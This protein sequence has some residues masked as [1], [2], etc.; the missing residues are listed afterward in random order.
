MF[1]GSESYVLQ[2]SKFGSVQDRLRD[3]RDDVREKINHFSCMQ[4]AML[5]IDGFRLDKAVQM[6]ADGLA[7]FSRAQR[8][9][10]RNLGKDNFL[11]L[12]ELL[13]R[14]PLINMYIGRGK[15]PHQHW[16]TPAE[17]M[18]AS[19]ESD[20]TEFI[21]DSELASLDGSSFS[22]EVYYGLVELLG[23]DGKYK[24]TSIDFVQL[25][26]D[27]LL[28]ADM[29]NPNTGL[30]DPR[31]GYGTT[32]QDLF[33][34]PTLANGT[35]RQLLGNFI[36]TLLMPGLPALTWGE[37]Q[38]AYILDNSAGDYVYGRAPM[39]SS[40]AWQIHGCY[41]LD[42]DVY[43]DLPL[44]RAR[45]GCHDDRVSLDQ[46][47]PAHP[48][49]NALKRMYE[50]REQYPALNDG[51][52]LQR[53]SNQT[54]DVYLPA[55]QLSTSRGIFSVYRSVVEELQNFEG[56]MMG[57]QG[58]WLVFSNEHSSTEFLFDCHNEATA[59]LAPFRPDTRVKSLFYPYEEHVLE[60]SSEEGGCLSSLTLP[61]WGFKAFV[62]IESFAPPR[63]TITEFLPGH[64]ERILS[65]E[66]P[67][68]LH[69][70]PIE[71]HF[72][73][74]MDCESVT[75]SLEVTS[76]TAGGP[77]ARIKE[78]SVFCSRRF[79][80]QGAYK[81]AGTPP[82]VW[83][84]AAELTH[85]ADGIHTITVTNASAED[86]AASTNAVDRFMFR[87]GAAD[88]PMVFPARANYTR[89]LLRRDD[90]TG[91]L[92]LAP[93]AAGADKFRYS[94][95]WGSSWSAWLD[96]DAAEN[97]ALEDHEWTGTAKQEWQG[98]HVVV[99]YWS[100]VAASSHHVQHA[101]LDDDQTERRWPHAFVEGTFNEFG[102]DT[103]SDGSMRLNG[104]GVWTFNLSAEWPVQATVNVW[105]INPDGLRDRSM[106]FGDVDGDGVLDL[107]PPDSLAPNVF[108]I[109]AGPG[110]PYVGWQIS[111]HDGKFTYHLT[112]VGSGNAQ[113]MLFFFLA[114]FPLLTAIVAG[115][116]Y[117]K[118]FYS[119]AQIG[120]KRYS[121]TRRLQGITSSLIARF[122]KQQISDKTIPESRA[123]LSSRRVLMA[124]LEYSIDDWNI[125]VRIGGLGV[126]ASLAARVLDHQEL[127]WVVP[128]L[129]DVHYPFSSHSEAEP[130]IVRLCGA[131]YR[132]DV[133]Y[134][135]QHNIT[136]VL[137]DAPIFRQRTRRAPYPTR[138]DDLES[139]IFYSAW[140][141]CIAEALR[142]FPVDLYHINDFHGA[143]APL[144]L[145]PHQ[146]VPVA[147]SL[148][149]AEFQGAWPLRT[150]EECAEM[151]AL[152]DLD[153]Q[154]VREY[155]R[156]GDVFNPLHAAVRY[157]E[158]HQKG[159]G[160]VGVSEKYALRAH[161]RYPV[162]W[163][164][165]SVGALPNPDPSDLRGMMQHDFSSSSASASSSSTDEQPDSNPEKEQRPDDRAASLA[166]A[167]T[168][169]NLHPNPSASLFVFVG[170]WCKQ[171]GID[172]IADVFAS[173][174]LPAH[175]SAQLVCLGPVVDLHGQLAA[176]KLAAAQR[177]F[178]GRVCAVPHFVAPPPCLFA[179]AEFVLI[180]SR[181]EPFG[182][183]S[184]EF[185]RK[186]ALG[187][188]PRIGGL[189]EM[190]GWWYNAESME[191][192]HLLAQLE[193]AVGLA[194]GSSRE[195][196]ARMRAEAE[197]R[198]FP[199]RRW[200][201]GLD[202]LQGEVVRVHRR[203]EGRAWEVEM[204]NGDV[205]A[206]QSVCGSESEESLLLRKRDSV[207]SGDTLLDEKEDC[208]TTVPE[209]RFS[210]H[211]SNS[212]VASLSVE[213]VVGG[214]DDFQLQ[215]CPPVFDDAD[216][217]YQAKFAQLLASDDGTHSSQ[218]R[219][220]I[221]D[222]IYR[223]E[224]EWF[225]FHHYGEEPNDVQL[226]TVVSLSTPS[227]WRKSF[228]AKRGYEAVP[229]ESSLSYPLEKGVSRKMQR[230]ILMYRI[231]NW[232]L[233]SI[234][235]A[236]VG[237]C[238]RC[239]SVLMGY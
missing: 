81:Y 87:I 114:I 40:Q 111:V 13:E 80:R 235:I 33:R 193:D 12:G 200:V 61:E 84:F 198:R 109:T 168:W 66:P 96:Y 162:F 23:L 239:S 60:A 6:T 5:D 110:M 31:H 157:V 139:A 230:S 131:D 105:G 54:H 182:L 74:P 127:I 211:F 192:R 142:R 3:W 125:H 123:L 159:V 47:N 55:R 59:L 56:T 75:R 48:V 50:L 7:D 224:K 231:G 214:R 9:C 97:F 103:L 226:P 122:K 107:L 24:K 85:V 219:T 183:V 113:R 154:T 124:T 234:L 186:G 70:I 120:L 213:A 52:L 134:H 176:L 238:V 160:V 228:F 65:T 126:M 112:P 149:N 99:E 216:G 79:F 19:N 144:Y 49:R 202:A 38:D 28:Q 148:H 185:G 236:L 53:L 187:I 227:W 69:T 63:P 203:R 130:M 212:N 2:L 143:L 18:T 194:L 197:G 137:L 78:A 128:C 155:V 205:T 218:R 102:L 21:R 177:R 145:L 77:T 172:L 181:D 209:K 115:W 10:A 116:A 215:D 190:P 158:R 229:L 8:E 39:S 45:T 25:W 180:P 220:C 73:A 46:K 35:Q 206:V 15:E 119:I 16:R 184:V 169:A 233:Y 34:W 208:L 163:T 118:S 91:R 217:E 14:R 27:Y 188:G 152:F 41:S 100:R 11:V 20:W 129:G 164:L 140:N 147:V 161:A 204:R 196:R 17:A 201:E 89:G 106:Q 150:Q 101:D 71:L 51:F 29:I 136:F 92:Y 30:F 179:A 189:G 57:N 141:A 22:Y 117:K 199:V 237:S 167:Q 222:F 1:G 191:T 210:E 32:N 171:K 195:A 207:S 67:D 178:L 95:D 76:S 90:S 26:E 133:H 151:A 98:E 121:R 135:V 232:P 93:R 138:M 174:I 44:E 68:H 108:N 170:R 88:N 225:R 156:F 36:T 58:V 165:P 153:P 86:G 166:Q 82:S 175:P 4:I 146:T 62:P 72:S 64:D 83:V 132:V 221:A 42:H 37:E 94:R 223:S 104:G 43:A 173:T